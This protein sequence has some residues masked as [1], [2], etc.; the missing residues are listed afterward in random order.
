[1]SKSRQFLL[2]G[3]CTVWSL[4]LVWPVSLSCIQP[5]LWRYLLLQAFSFLRFQILRRC[6]TNQPSTRHALRHRNLRTRFLALRAWPLTFWTQNRSCARVLMNGYHV[7]QI[8]WCSLNPFCFIVWKD[9]KDIRQ[10]QPTFTP[11]LHSV[12]LG[13]NYPHI[14]QAMI[15]F[16]S[17]LTGPLFRALQ[18]RPGPL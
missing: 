16:G 5:Q 4:K 17:C 14:F 1:M 9:V 7:H 15:S 2:L 18:A 13:Q 12:R 8:W 6:T 11:S 3:D 10:M